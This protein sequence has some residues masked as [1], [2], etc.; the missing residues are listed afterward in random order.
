MFS[1]ALFF[2]KLDLFGKVLSHEYFNIYEFLKYGRVKSGRNSRKERIIAPAMSK[3]K[4]Y[5][6]DNV[7]GTQIVKLCFL[8]PRR[9]S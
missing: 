3:L 7:S 8:K 2:F 6:N 4:A 1:K 9:T 5:G